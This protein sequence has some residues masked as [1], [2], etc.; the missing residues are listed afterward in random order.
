MNHWISAC[1]YIAVA[2][3]NLWLAYAGENG[4]LGALNFLAFAVLLVLGL[5][6]IGR[7]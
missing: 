5:R 4:T 2:A 6:E 1:I 7:A 3:F